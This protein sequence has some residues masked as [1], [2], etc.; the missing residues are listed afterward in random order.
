MPGMERQAQRPDPS[1][2]IEQPGLQQYETQHIPQDSAA[3]AVKRLR[4]CSSWPQATAKAPPAKPQPGK[5]LGPMQAAKLALASACTQ[6]PALQVISRKWS[7][8]S[9][10]TDRA[11]QPA[12]KRTKLAGADEHRMQAASTSGHAQ[13][14][15][16]SARSR[17]SAGAVCAKCEKPISP[18]A[19]TCADAWACRGACCQSFHS[20]C[21]P[22]RAALTCFECVGGMRVCFFCKRLTKAAQLTQCAVASCGRFYHSQCAERW[23][24]AVLTSNRHPSRCACAQHLHDESTPA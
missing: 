7:Y 2:S 17:V 12:A 6:G 18:S 13:Q 19:A 11:A 20:A 9:S 15:H 14:M 1:H 23:A 8:S 16:L 5:R 22:P 3:L 24:G 10:N 21:A 4:T